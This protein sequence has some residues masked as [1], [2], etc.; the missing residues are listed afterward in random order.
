MT[1]HFG[2]IIIFITNTA[3]ELSQAEI[4]RSKK[5]EKFFEIANNFISHFH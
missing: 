1:S 2:D 3:N 4:S 5:T